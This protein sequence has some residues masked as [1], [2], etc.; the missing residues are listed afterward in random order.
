M[1]MQHLLCGIIDLGSNTIRLSIYSSENGAVRLLL[2]KKVMAGLSGYVAEGTLS[3]KGIAKACSVLNNF[4]SILS[5]FKIDCAYVFATASLRNISNTEEATGYIAKNTGL[6]ITVLTGEE[7]ARLVFAGAT[8]AMDVTSG[9]MVDIG[10][11]STEYAA[12]SHNEILKAASMPIGS[13]NL[14]Y[15]YVSALLP[16]SA[17][18]KK[19]RTRVMSELKDSGFLTIGRQKQICGVGG[20]VRAARKLYNEIFDLP[21]ENLEMEP[22][23]LDRLFSLFETDQKAV[24]RSILQIAPDRIHTIIPG[25]IILNTIAKGCTCEKITVS[26]YGVREGYLFDRVLSL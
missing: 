12:F 19:I 2:N 14:F 17:N 11:G 10:G 23:K 22:G 25:M 13:L 9:L 6:D 16:T 5:N 26:G 24:Y 21:S 15:K 20:S 7:E 3:V 4:K 8:R 1:E 18:M